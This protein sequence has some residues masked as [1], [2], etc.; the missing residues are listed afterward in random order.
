MKLALGTVQFGLAYGIANK[1]GQ[2]GLR[3]AR[4]IMAA[5]ARNGFD[6]LDTA[7]AYGESERRLGE[8]GIQGWNVIS[9][10]PA[11]PDGCGDVGEWVRES[12]ERSLDALKTDRLYGLLLHRPLQLFEGYGQHLYDALTQLRVDGKV[13]KI[14]LSIY[15]PSE[16]DALCPHYSVDL[17]QGPFNLLDR[18]ILNTGWL[19]KLADLGIEFHARSLFLQGLLLMAAADRP[20]AFHRWDGLWRVWHDWLEASKMTP[21]QACLRYVLAFP[22]IARVVVGVDSSLQ[23]EEIVAAT[24][25]TCPPLPEGLATDDLDLINPCRWP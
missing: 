18:R 10:L 7:I 14:G 8:L 12:V 20:A 4:N 9:K 2:V 22:E 16:L 6:T 25:G 15:A 24:D 23:L 1:S 21:L 5:A 3:E 11:V 17:V 13:A 19:A